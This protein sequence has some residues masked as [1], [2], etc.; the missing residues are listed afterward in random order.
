M[1]RS[2]SNIQSNDRPIQSRNVSRA[3]IIIY[4]YNL[5]WKIFDI[6]GEVSRNS[7]PFETRDELDSY[8]ALLKKKTPK[9]LNLV[10][11]I[12]ELST[13]EIIDKMHKEQGKKN[14]KR[15]RDDRASILRI[16]KR[17]R[18]VRIK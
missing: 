2:E 6:T 1:G 16:D 15:V 17:R 12:R 11:N 13:N 9:N 18:T 5:E 3:D 10:V 8:L 4:K 14:F 7:K